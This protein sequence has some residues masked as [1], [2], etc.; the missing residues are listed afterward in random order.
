MRRRSTIGSVIAAGLACGVLSC[1]AK[2]ALRAPCEMPLRGTRPAFV[3]VYHKGNS[4]VRTNPNDESLY[5]RELDEEQLAWARWFLPEL[6][7][8]GVLVGA[9]PWPDEE[10]NTPRWLCSWSD[11]LRSPIV[12]DG[13]SSAL[14]YMLR[15]TFWVRANSPVSQQI[16]VAV[17]EL[18]ALPEDVHP[19]VVVLTIHTDVNGCLGDDVYATEPFDWHFQR[20]ARF[21]EEGFPTLVVGARLDGRDGRRLRLRVPPR[22][23]EAGG[24]PWVDGPDLWYDHRYDREPLLRA[25]ERAILHPAYCVLRAPEG[26]DDPDAWV[27]QAP[28]V[29][30]IERDRTRRDGWDWDDPAAGSVR[31]FGTVCE[32]VAHARE[33]PRLVTRAWRCEPPAR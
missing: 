28:S 3:V 4:T 16:E 32:R 23:A 14:D 5:G 20:V 26:T 33:R 24:L 13:G 2:T 7:R 8:G 1:G 29:G 25:A 21:R 9:S 18:R 22:Y 11:V 15:E 12:D 17:R 31:L 27:L 19:R 30:T 6:G 10:Y